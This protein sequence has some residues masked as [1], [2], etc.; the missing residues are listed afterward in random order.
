MKSDLGIG[1][2]M[3]FFGGDRAMRY[4]TR[5]V[6]GVLLA[7]VVGTIGFGEET[8]APWWHFGRDKEMSSA[9]PAVTPAPSVAPAKTFSPAMP[10]SPAVT[11]TENDSWVSWPSMPKLSWFEP[12]AETQVATTEPFT[13]TSPVSQGKKS[14]QVRTHYGKPTH[15]SRPKNTW[16]QQ[17]ASATSAKPGTSAWK[18]MTDGTRKAWHKTVDY[19]TPGESATEA[20]VVST[21]P[22]PSWWARMW[23]A[24][25]KPQGPQT[26]TEWMAQDRLDP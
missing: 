1:S 21:D 24:G 5:P 25:D 2:A 11:P 4:T 8:K 19:V 15:H 7:V 23:G 16:A 9:P 6:L 20:P 14:R 10:M 26:V 13:A 17:P 22:G 12:S 3:I 18:S